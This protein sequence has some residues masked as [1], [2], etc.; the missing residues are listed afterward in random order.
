M[1]KVFP[2]L[3][4]KYIISTVVTLVYMFLLH[5]SD[6]FALQNGKSKVRELESQIELKKTE[7]EDLKIALNDLDSPRSLEK[8]AREYH[9]FKKNDED[10]FIFSF[11]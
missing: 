9:Y 4:N 1:K 3:K 7:I 5:E 10:V 6:I 2:I 8:Y 11:E